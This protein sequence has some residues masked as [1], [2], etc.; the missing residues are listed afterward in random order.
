M[1][2]HY[3]YRGGTGFVLFKKEAQVVESARLALERKL[4][5]LLPDDDP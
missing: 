3:R 4:E 5:S 2:S 1:K